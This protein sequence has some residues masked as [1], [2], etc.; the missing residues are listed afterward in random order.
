MLLR[1]LWYSLAG[2]VACSVCSR[3]VA[4]FLF[5]AIKS[6]L[7]TVKRSRS[8]SIDYITYY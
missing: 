8:S 7:T 2:A 6:E 4:V 1:G 3:V 5:L